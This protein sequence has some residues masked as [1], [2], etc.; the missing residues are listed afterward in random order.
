MFLVLAVAAVPFS[1]DGTLR[2]GQTLAI[3]DVNGNVRVRT[4]DRLAVRATKHAEHGDPN[5]VAIHVENGASGIV[6]CVRYPPDAD[7][8]C[9]DG[10][11]RRHR[12]NGSSDNDTAVDFDVTVPH[13][14]V[15]DAQT[16]N[17]SVDVIND[18][19][20]DAATV[21]GSVSV[22]ARDVRS[23]TTVNGAVTVRVL[24]RTNTSLSA[25]TVNGAIDV[26]LPQGSGVELAANTLTGDISAAGVTVERPRYGPG[27][28]AKATLG[29]GARRVS[30]ST[31]NGSIAL[32]R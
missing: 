21:N 4:G 30:L 32:H 5:A 25:K 6:V 17:G 22:E 18:G 14:V 23:A 2:P 19:P 11:A 31:V 12:S 7:R 9:G 13:G 26:T 10:T 20:A 1:Y 27:A 15:L 29:D 16:V 24:D 28:H 3:H 8:A